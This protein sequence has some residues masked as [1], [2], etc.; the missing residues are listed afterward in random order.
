M[1]AKQKIDIE[2]RLLVVPAF[3][4][5]LQQHGML[6]LVETVKQFT[7]FN[8]QILIEESSAKRTV[9]WK[10]HGLSAPAMSMPAIGGARYDKIYFGLSGTVHFTLIKKDGQENTVTVKVSPTG[11]KLIDMPQ[12]SFIAV[13]TGSDEFEAKRT[14]D[15]QKPSHKPDIHRAVPGHK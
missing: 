12:H 14:D 11:V 6:F 7:N 10:I 3:D 15:M 9:T 5:T 8:Y 4:E 1:A 13:Y 2:Y